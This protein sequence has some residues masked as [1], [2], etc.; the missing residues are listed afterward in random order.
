M[1]IEPIYKLQLCA[2][3]MVE[4]G[5]ARMAVLTLPTLSSEIYS[6]TSFFEIALKTLST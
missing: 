2:V 5:L 1:T 4:T 3:D 6:M